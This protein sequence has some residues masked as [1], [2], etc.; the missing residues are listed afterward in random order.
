MRECILCKLRQEELPVTKLYE[1]DILTV[2]MDIKPINPGHV[3]LFPRKCVEKMID[4]DDE[5]I[6]HMFIIAKKINRAI[7]D[8][9]IKCTDMNYYVSDG[10]HAGQEI[11]HVHLHLIPRFKGDGFKFKFPNSYFNSPT[12]LELISIAKQITNSID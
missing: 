7:R 4:L 12:R 3:L 10:K 6:A 2:I 11:P 5:I 8:S 9:G 1:D